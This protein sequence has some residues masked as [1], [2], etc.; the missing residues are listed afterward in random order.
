MRKKFI[1][2]FKFKITIKF[3]KNFRLYSMILIRI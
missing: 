1:F 2:M 3:E